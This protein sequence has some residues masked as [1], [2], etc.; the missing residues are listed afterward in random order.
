MNF[1]HLF[2]SPPESS[3][4]YA[5]NYDPVLV[6]LSIIIAT[7]ASYASLLV[8]QHISNA[9]TATVRR[10]WIAGGGLCLGIGI[11]A[12]HFV[13]MLAFSLPC[14][15]SYEPTITFLST[16]PSIFASILAL[17]IISRRELSHVQLVI[18]GLLIGSGIGAMHY[19]GM[20][21]MRLNGL[22]R[23]DIKLFLLSILVAIVLA[24]FAL[25]IRF[26]LQSWQV[27]WNTWVTIAS[28][29][30]M[31]LAVSGMHYTAMAA[32]YF[33]RDGDT[34]SV[35][36]GIDP[37]FLSAIV[38]SATSLIVVLTIIATYV[39]KRNL[40]SFGRNY[41][42]IGVLIIGWTAI[43]WLSADYYYNRLASSLYTQ[44]L[45]LATQQAEQV[46]SDIDE[47]IE[48][49]KGISLVFSNDENIHRALRLFGPDAE[50]SPMS[51][52]ERKQ[53][54]AHDKALTE[55]NHSLN[56]AAANL[57]A[58]VIWI[59]N[60]AGDTF[61]SS[62][63]DKTDSFVGA[64]YSDREYFRQAQ[65]GQRGHQY[66]V[67]K[68]SK[69]PGLYY[70]HPIIEQGRFLGA[71]I[72]K[73]NITSLSRG[74]SQANLF[75]A[76]SNG[77]IVLSSNK[78]FEFHALPNASVANMTAEK[79]MLQ[80]KQASIESLAIAP[81]GNKRFSSAV[82]IG[83][84]KTPIVLT[85]KT[86]SEDALTIYA[87]RPLNKFLRLVSEKNWLFILLMTAGGMLIVAASMV[88]LYLRESNRTA[89]D[90]RISSTAFESQESM[91]IT[92][93][94]SVVLR[95][96]QAF[97]ET[98]GYT[99]EEIV[100]QNPR[101]LKSGRHNAAFYAAMWETI[102]N[103]GGWQGEI[104]D[105][106]K[107]GEIYPKWLTITAVKQSDGTITH[108]VG[109][110]LDITERKAA[111][112]KINTLAF[113]DPLTLL[114]NR[115]L[116]MARLQHALASSSRSGRLG[117]LLF[118]DMDNFKT[119]NDTLGH[120]IGDLL[121]KQVAQRLNSNIRE[122]DT[123]ARLGGDE[124]LVILEVLS[125]DLHEAAAQTELIG[126]NI[127][128]TINQ[129]YQLGLHEYDISTSI[130]TTLFNGQ[131]TSMDELMKQA[132]IAMYQAKKAGRN[133]LR[134][135]DEQMQQTISMHAAL[136]ISLRK[137]LENQQFHLYYQI[138]V[139]NLLLP[140]GAE[141]LI[142]WIQPEHGIVSPA[143][144]IPL[145]EETGLI[146]PIGLWVLETACAQLNR[147]QKDAHTRDLV[148]AVNVSAIQFRQSDF[149][150]QVQ[151][152]MQRYAIQPLR[153]KLELTESLLL[154]DIES[155]I[156]TMNALKE[157]GVQ[158]SLDD[159]GTGYSSLQ[160]LKRLPLNQLKI[161]QSFVRDIASDSNDRAI[162]NTIITM[163]HSLNLDVIAE[164]VET[165]EQRKLL[166]D[167]GCIHYQG[168]LF[169]KPEPIEQ[170]EILLQKI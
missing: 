126:E 86:L 160:Y 23:Y 10:L 95:V 135:F 102:K 94:N 168:Y 41:R 125:N 87:F 88:V 85:S 159:F 101:L 71:V 129:P 83:E 119:L 78:Q 69:V 6:S 39:G 100:G 111:E 34:T 19:S 31:G 153:L 70:S 116:L 4:L 55:L 68:T 115:R 43:A 141:A 97:T 165:E 13:G 114:P 117:A 57:R 33:I 164:G 169:G 54:W 132:D 18:G 65:T 74:T 20:A 79:I 162:V 28:A 40:L 118:I 145:A 29:M 30:V 163:A 93:A 155:I 136:E 63:A 104:W 46:A 131:K 152:V 148:L 166:L 59:M 67:G 24:T 49:L 80:Y 7:F 51:L 128:A 113:Y 156:A 90:L 64:N 60:A 42:L 157:I 150:Y 142:R 11:W 76:D 139:D 1:L 36:S 110:H 15:S 161:D 133:T 32:A 112:E 122:G 25:W 81:W 77:V 62:N 98:T 130:G 147:W 8:S 137:A 106:R 21:A 92:D 84:E 58:D 127:L 16:I 44:E 82:F 134:F 170:F 53:L 123:V 50:P 149:V 99:T 27:R 89:S 52:A 121:L 144:F 38:L 37:A 17:K 26:R 56:I 120:D 45:H 108:Y 72:V 9:T 91:M 48:L 14:S 66:A 96:N 3:L 138:Q 124:F 47:N 140:L 73:R 158:F 12:M 151:A 2:I 75:V 5:G 154:E 103:T 143:Q 107:N 109:S 105:R 61:S 167:S 146:L 22:I 35:P